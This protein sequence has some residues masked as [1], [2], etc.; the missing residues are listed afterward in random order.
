MDFS[1]WSHA[2][3][4]ISL[5][6]FQQMTEYIQEVHGFDEENVTLLMD[7]G[8]HTE[9]TRENILAAYEKLVNESEEGDIVFCHFSGM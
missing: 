3:L 6:L 2:H 5:F 8:E 4:K 9:P 1:S 7:D